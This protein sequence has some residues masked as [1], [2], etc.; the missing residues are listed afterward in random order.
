MIGLS[1]GLE[2]IQAA[3][4]YNFAPIFAL[5]PHWE[6]EFLAPSMVCST[7]DAFNI[8]CR[9]DRDGKLDEAPQNKKQSAG[10]SQLRG[11]F[12]EQD[13]AE[14][15]SLRASKALGPISRYRVADIV[16]HLKLA[17]GASRPGLL[18]GSTHLVQRS[19]FDIKIS[20]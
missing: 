13:F 17:S 1:Q 18:V 8:V 15:L 14:P 11:K 20:N 19:V 16:P 4:G 6:N 2:N 5:S 3:R 9:L 10:T 7:A 12:F